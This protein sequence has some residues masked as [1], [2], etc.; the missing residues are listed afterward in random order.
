MENMHDLFT[1]VHICC[2]LS[3][4]PL[5]MPLIPN[6]NWLWLNA[7]CHFGF[8][9]YSLFFS[10]SRFWNVPLW[11]IFLCLHFN[12][13][14]WNTFHSH[15]FTNFQRSMIYTNKANAKG[16]YRQLSRTSY[17]SIDVSWYILFKLL[18]KMIIHVMVDMADSLFTNHIFKIDNNQC[19]A[20]NLWE[21]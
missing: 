11:F 2:N 15:F 4:L 16:S 17:R 8:S 1:F 20:S 6:R 12:Y 3:L 18:F 10:P 14:N 5:I 13:M 21:F 7:K 9:I 19:N